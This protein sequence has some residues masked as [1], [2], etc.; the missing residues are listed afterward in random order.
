MNAFDEFENSQKTVADFNKYFCYPLEG[1]DKT[2]PVE[3]GKVSIGWERFLKVGNQE[4]KHV[5]R[6]SK[7]RLERV[8]KQSKPVY[9]PSAKVEYSDYRSLNKE[10][11]ELSGTEYKLLQVLKTF[12]Q[13]WHTKEGLALSLKMAVKTVQNNLKDLEKKGYVK[14]SRTTRGIK[15]EE[16]C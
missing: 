11:I 12:G 5:V 3:I 14:L 7:K 10:L 16:L 2:A 6:P 15:V 4:I 1:F 9:V 13:A 8:I